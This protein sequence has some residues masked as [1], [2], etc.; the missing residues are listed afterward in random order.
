MVRRAHPES[1]AEHRE[2]AYPGQ[3]EKARFATHWPTSTRPV[4]ATFRHGLVIGRDRRDGSIR[5]LIVP[6]GVAYGSDTRKVEAILREIA[7]A[8]PLVLVNPAPLIVFAGFGADSLNFEIRAILSPTM[9]TEERSVIAS[10]AG[11]NIRTLRMRTG[12]S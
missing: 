5:R 4:P 6:V 7:E 3:P 2:T 1:A 10:A 12:F 11:S 8:Q 9:T